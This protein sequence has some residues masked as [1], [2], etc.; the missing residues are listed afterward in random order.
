MN[1]L[2]YNR[3]VNSKNTKIMNCFYCYI[4]F[5][6]SRQW[7]DMAQGSVSCVIH[8][9][10]LGKVRQTIEFLDNFI[11]CYFLRRYSWDKMQD[12]Y[13]PMNSCSSMQN[14]SR[15]RH[16][17]ADDAVEI[18]SYLNTSWVQQLRLV[19]AVVVLRR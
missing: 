11:Y 16:A 9:L 19:T 7:M 15:W 13:M 14:S 4:H 10:L 17:L 2:F 8:P 12:T 3:T 18:T 1:Y 6:L 5:P